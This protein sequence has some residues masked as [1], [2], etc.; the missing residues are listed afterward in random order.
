MA[1]KSESTRKSFIWLASIAAILTLGTSCFLDTSVQPYYGVAKAPKAQELRWSDGGLPKV[2]DPALAA[3]PPDTDAVRAMYEGLT[4]FDS[5]ASSA[6]PAL[7]TSWAAS[8]DSR[9]W[10][11]YLRR[12]ARWSNGDLVTAH[13]FVRSWRRVLNMGQ[14]SPNARL[15]ANIE[16]AT[17]A[18]SPVAVPKPSPLAPE[19]KAK[20]EVSQVSKE[21]VTPQP[22][23]SPTVKPLGIEAIDDYS[24]RIHLDQPDKDFPNLVAHPGFR[25]VH[26]ENGVELSAQTA[27]SNGAF[28]LEQSGS[29]GVVLQR[30]SKYWNSGATKLER[31]RFMAFSNPES[32]LAAYKAGDVDAVSNAALEPLAI[33]LLTPFGDFKRSTYAALTLYN[34]NQNKPP[35]NDVKV[36][37][38]LTISIDRERISQD[39]MGGSTVPADKFLPESQTRQTDSSADRTP[40]MD[41]AV[42]RAKALMAQAGF[43]NGLGFPR[44]SLLIN[45]NEQ[46]RVVAQTV[47]SMWKTALNID[48][49][50]VSRSWDEYEAALGAGQYDI[51][52]R[53][54]VM[55]APD[56]QLILSMLFEASPTAPAAAI[57]EPTKQPDKTETSQVP[58]RLDASNSNA[59]LQSPSPDIQ[60]ENIALKRF[61]AIP[62]FFASS[63]SLVKPYVAGFETNLQDAPL[64]KGVK[65]DTTWQPPAKPKDLWWK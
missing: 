52:R 46:Q 34:F 40:N 3:A 41:A 43:P 42:S 59:A 5:S 15:L 28:E 14:K 4:E 27:V 24:L 1:H 23:P 57:P 50:V 35:F 55:P 30:S 44:I 32:A 8:T 53:S 18:P 29:D 2:F 61:A 22:E 51:A 54:V 11:F 60:N 62:L 7:A 33:K 47:A 37:E 9:T 6:V 12:N 45:R 21:P 17:P 25:P 13:D 20:T 49:D 58:S 48:T 26:I 19:S 38:A 56:E 36:R 10:T 63:Y 16:G 31:V 64:L 39:V 65:I